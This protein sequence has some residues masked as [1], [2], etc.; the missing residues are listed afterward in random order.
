MD[1]DDVLEL[2]RMRAGAL[3]K[4]Y[5]REQDTIELLARLVADCRDSIS[6]QDFEAFVQIGGTLCKRS[7]ANKRARAEVTATVQ[8]ACPPKQ[9]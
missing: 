1:K 3:D 6:D 2:F 5:T 9:L 8:G 4:A 7:A